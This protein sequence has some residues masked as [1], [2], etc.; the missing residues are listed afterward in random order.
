MDWISITNNIWVFVIGVISGVIVAI[1]STI[2]IEFIPITSDLRFKTKFFRKKSYKWLTNEEIKS[3]LNIK[4]KNIED[5]K[6]DI[7]SF[8][9][10]IKKQLIMHKIKFFEKENEL[11]FE[12]LEG[13]AKISTSLNFALNTITIDDNEIFIV[14]QLDVGLSTPIKFRN[15][16]GYILDLRQGAEKITEIIRDVVSNIRIEYNLI[17]QLKNLYEL[18]GVLSKSNL[19][20]LSIKDENYEIEMFS[21]QVISYGKITQEL[22]SIMKNLI[23]IY[24]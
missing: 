20:T 7:I 17:F 10:K 18:T 2:L 22:T 11:S 13:K 5:R 16:D 12:M 15:F 3:I 14:S 19:N 6:L 24:N 21:N 23:V 1:I 8:K 9:E 4:V